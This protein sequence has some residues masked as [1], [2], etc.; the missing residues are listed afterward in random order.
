MPCLLFLGLLEMVA[1]FSMAMA[2][3][4]AS[5]QI[6][7]N[8]TANVLRW[9]LGLFD[10]TPTGRIISRFSQDIVEIDLVLPFTVRSLIGLF[11]AILFKLVVIVY[12]TPYVVVGLP[13][14][15]IVY[16]FI[17][18]IIPSVLAVLNIRARFIKRYMF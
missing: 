11:Y 18:V 16:V 15:V 14:A 5:H 3:L 12:A 8:L 1:S 17:Q 4:V 13:V 9:P 2:G 10:R 6:H 7:A